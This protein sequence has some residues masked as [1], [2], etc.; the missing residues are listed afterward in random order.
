MV[1]I[2]GLIMVAQTLQGHTDRSLLQ[3]SAILVT[4]I[5]QVAF[6]SLP[7]IG[8]GEPIGEQSDRVRTLITPAG[9]AFSIC[10]PLFAGSFAYAIY[11]L[12]PLQRRNA[13]LAKIGWASA[14]AFLGNALWALHAQL[15]GLSVVSSLIIIFT[16]LCLLSVFRALVERGLTLSTGEKY[17]VAL[18][19]SALAA[20]LTAA[21]IVNISASLKYH[22]ITVEDGGLVAAAV[23]IIGGLIAAATV[24][25]GKGNPWYAT[26]FLWALAGI[27]AAAGAEQNLIRLAVMAA[28][29]FVVVATVVRLTSGRNWRHW[30][31]SAAI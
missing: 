12:L 20:W 5:L 13:L 19:L 31:G 6:S 1:P 26:V 7:V 11:Q 15:S 10:G 9:W 24:W 25:S 27:H 16:L 28:A 4:A 2:L 14:G 17:L 21:T 29:G 3:R 18:P 22:G 8:I 30:M 23:V